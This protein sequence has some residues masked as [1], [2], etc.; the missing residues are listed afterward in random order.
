M[1]TFQELQANLQ[2]GHREQQ[3]VSANSRI[4][5]REEKMASVTL[6]GLNELPEGT[7]VH[8]QLGKAFL[9]QPLAEV[10]ATM[11]A[12]V[13]SAAKDLTMLIE[14]KAYLDGKVIQLEQEAQEFIKAHLKPPDA[15]PAAASSSS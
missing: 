2:R 4:R 5:A 13:V 11:Q 9:T 8:T 10:K 7:R 15:K 14:K 6:V 1:A 12:R 3:S